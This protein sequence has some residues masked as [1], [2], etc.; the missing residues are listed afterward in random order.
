M[1]K[2][3]KDY[4]I[5]CHATIA[6]DIY[7]VRDRMFGLPGQFTEKKCTK[8][9]LIWLHPKPSGNELKKYYPPG[10][11]YSYGIN[12]R[13]SLFWRLR[14]YLILHSTHPSILSRLVGIL[15][16]VPAIPD[17]IQG[18][19]IM[20]VGCGSGDTLV[21]LKQIGWDV[22]G[23][24][25][26]SRAIGLAEKRGLANI[27]LGGYISLKDYP[28]NYFDAIRLYHVIEHL[29]DPV[30]C[31]QLIKKKLKKHGQLILGTPN[32][33]SVLATIGKQYW[34]NLDAPRHLYIFSP[35][36]LG[37]ILSREKFQVHTVRFCSGGGILGTLQYIW[38]EVLHKKI[39]FIN[40]T[41]LVACLFPIEYCLDRLALG[42]IIDVH[43]VNNLND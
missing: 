14:S 39:S 24:D 38:N 41:F 33:A 7:A 42:D 17:F 28:D 13:P 31:L 2:I 6:K 18:G 8:C 4:C 27:Q 21:L 34:Y 35:K 19:K 15:I 20:D 5:A 30:L 43:A 29:D 9:G 22:Y 10:N 32:G 26:D 16:R 3:T 37:I 25:I 12:A 1:A 40:N 23:L 36:T 11:Y